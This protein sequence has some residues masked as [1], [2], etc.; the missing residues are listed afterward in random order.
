MAQGKELQPEVNE[1]IIQVKK[2]FD[3]EKKD[4][5]FV[6]TK[7]PMNR[8]AEALGVGVATVKRMVARHSRTG[9][10]ISPP[11]RRPG[12]K[13]DN[14]CESVEVCVRDFIRSRNLAGSKVSVETVRSYLSDELQID[15]DKSTL[16]RG[17]NRWGFT[18]GAGRRRECLKERDYVIH[19]RRKYLREIRANRAPGGSCIRPEVYLDETYINKNHSQQRTWYDEDEGAWVNM[20]SGVGPRFIILNA[21]TCAGWVESAQLVFEAKKRMGDY[22][23]QMNWQNFSTW[24]EKSLLPNIPPESLIILDNA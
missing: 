6:S 19:A 17:L 15:I 4:G 2:Y 9:T 22:H 5:T 20:P 24:F 1:I 10:T 8:T 11:H 12:R 3:R 18:F 21:I 7:N 16:R 23:G 13:P 14:V